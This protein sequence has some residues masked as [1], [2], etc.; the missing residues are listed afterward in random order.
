MQLQSRPAVHLKLAPSLPGG[1]LLSCGFPFCSPCTFVYLLS[2]TFTR[3]TIVHISARSC[4]PLLH[5]TLTHS[6]LMHLYSCTSCTSRASL[7]V[8]LCACTSP[9]AHQLLHLYVC[10]PCTSPHAPLRMHPVHI[11]CTSTHAL[12]LACT[13][14]ASFALV[15]H[16]PRAPI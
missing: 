3:A 10:T 6:H 4:A 7:H 11:S 9:R 5:L 16:Q 13:S 12:H 8:H 15:Y 2:S 14:R 1:S